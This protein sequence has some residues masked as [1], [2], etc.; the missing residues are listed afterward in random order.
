MTGAVRILLMTVQRPRLLSPV[1]QSV[2]GPTCRYQMCSSLRLMNISV[3]L[4]DDSEI[5]RKAIA[6]LLKGDPEI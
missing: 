2:G 6:H 5:M 1:G 4:A 3:F